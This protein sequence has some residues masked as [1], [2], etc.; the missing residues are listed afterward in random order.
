MRDR[1]KKWEAVHDT[2]LSDS[3]EVVVRGDHYAEDSEAIGAV[4]RLNLS[5]AS[6]ARM[7]RR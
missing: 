5:G 6:S 2:G 7:P 1:L 4:G 3:L